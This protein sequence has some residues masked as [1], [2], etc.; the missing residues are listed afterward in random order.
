MQDQRIDRQRLDVVLDRLAE[1]TPEPVTDIRA[2]E[3][4]ALARTDEGGTSDVTANSLGEELVDFIMPRIAEPGIF[5]RSVS[6]L[7]HLAADVIPRLEGG[8]EL[9]SLATT[10]IEDEIGRHQDLLE[11]IHGGLET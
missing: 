10:L 1:R 5:Q 8:E 7:E 3:I 2:E 4:E 6:I 9:R 11:R